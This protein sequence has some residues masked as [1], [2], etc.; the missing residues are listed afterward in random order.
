MRS[1]VAPESRDACSWR[2][3][4]GGK[5]SLLVCQPAGPVPANC[6]YRQGECG[7]GWGLPPEGEG[8]GL[9]DHQHRRHPTMNTCK[10]LTQNPDDARMEMID[11]NKRTRIPRWR[12]LHAPSSVCIQY[13]PANSPPPKPPFSLFAKL[14]SQT[15]SDRILLLSCAA[16]NFTIDPSKPFLQT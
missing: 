14:T 9:S 16:S 6:K 2:V 8:G 12:H 11:S 3:G 15:Q 4:R 10:H 7:Q 5:V 13:A 1:R